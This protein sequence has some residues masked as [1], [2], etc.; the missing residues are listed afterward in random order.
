MR[1]VVEW[2][3]SILVYRTWPRHSK[4]NGM[5]MKKRDN[6]IGL[7]LISILSALSL[8]GCASVP[9]ASLEQDTEAKKFLPKPNMSRIY[10][11]RNERIGAALTMTATLDGRHTGQTAAGTYLIWD[12]M[13]GKH[14]ITSRTEAASVPILLPPYGVPAPVNVAA[15]EYSLITLETEA[16]RAYYIWQEV[17]WGRMGGSSPPKLH[18]VNQQDGQAGVMACRLAQSVSQPAETDRPKMESI[19]TSVTAIVL[20]KKVIAQESGDLVGIIFGALLDRYAKENTI[21]STDEEVDAFVRRL[22]QK[23]KQ[24][25]IKFEHDRERLLKELKSS[26]LSEQERKEKSSQLEAIEEFLGTM[27]EMK[28]QARGMEEPMRTMQRQMAQHVVRTWKINKSLYDKYGGRVIF[29]QA[30]PEPIDAYLQF[31]KEQEKAGTFQIL[32]K[33]YEASFWDYF[34]NDAIHTFYSPEDGAKFINTPWWLMNSPP[35]E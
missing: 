19:D 1:S 20:E 2:V 33:K 5:A 28:A 34:I 8:A 4:D 15:S 17:K 31:L 26:D 9:M 25:Q 21:E 32:D 24:N 16:G 27:R 23:E 7:I 11:F 13:P 10:L 30:G 14:E 3:N 18:L 12:V 6:I 35:D 29:Q 22:G